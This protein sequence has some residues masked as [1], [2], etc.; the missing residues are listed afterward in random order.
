MKIAELFVRLTADT[1]GLKGGLTGAQREL[2]KFG[3]NAGRV[4]GL[5]GAGLFTGMVKNSIEAQNAIAQLNAVVKS[6]GGAAGFATPQLQALA[7]E[8]QKVSVFSDEAIMS[9]QGLLLT[10]TN[11]R[12]AE[13]TGATKAVLDLAQAMGGDLKGAAVQVGKALNDPKVGLT[14]LRRVGVSFSESQIAVIK[15][16]Q[17]TGQMVEAQRL[18][19]AELEVQFGGSAEA[20][21]NTLGGALKALS[22]AFG[23]TLEVSGEASAGIVGAINRIT[24]SLP[25]LRRAADNAFTVWGEQVKMFKRD[26]VI[27]G[28]VIV[29]T[30]T[31]MAEAAGAFYKLLTFGQW[32]QHWIDEA[33]RVRREVVATMKAM[34]AEI[35]EDFGWRKGKHFGMADLPAGVGN[36]PKKPIVPPLFDEDAAGKA[37]AKLT[38]G[39]QDLLALQGAMKEAGMNTK[40]VDDQIFA[41]YQRINAEIAKGVRLTNEQLAA[42]IRLKTELAAAMAPRPGNVGLTPN[43][44]PLNPI[45]VKG[46]SV[47]GGKDQYGN[48]VGGMFKVPTAEEMEKA[49]QAGKG[50]PWWKGGKSQDSMGTRVGQVLQAGGGGSEMGQMVQAF[51][52][53]GPMAAILPVINGAMEKLGPAFHKLIEPLIELGGTIGEI[54]APVFE[55]LAPLVQLT[56]ATFKV[57]EPV[58]KMVV[59]GFSYLMQGLGMVVKAVGKLIDSLPFV[60][61]KGIIRAGQEMIDAARAARRNADATDKATDAVEKFASSLS[62]IPRVLNVNAL[63]HMVTGGGGGSDGGG[64][65]KQWWKRRGP[66]MSPGGPMDTGGSVPVNVGTV[67]ININGAGD[68]RQVA[69]EVGRV[70][71]R[72]GSRGGLSRLQVALA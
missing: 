56:A 66:G 43:G 14:A 2:D 9:A 33:Q 69:E 25:A 24:E 60:K 5:V 8:F 45:T 44:S 39:M 23:D 7:S 26:F 29:A 55:M 50:S 65:G 63:R 71:E 13:L 61:A 31:Y 64:G 36:L 57:F 21:R 32:G 12:G 10:F 30:Y 52:S 3:R 19:L 4:A 54:L 17:E 38:G 72:T 67:N 16:L 48:R 22:N 1:S 15:K 20:A 42:A 58:L 68:P 51:A 41:A 37:F 62:N 47:F 49:R 46:S 27:A 11:I 70:I 59:K 18:I 6:T 34:Q 53:F 35:N 28:G 40:S